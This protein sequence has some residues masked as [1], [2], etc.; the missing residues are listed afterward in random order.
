MCRLRRCCRPDCKCVEILIGCMLLVL[1]TVTISLIRYFLEF[2]TILNGFG[3]NVKPE[4]PKFKDANIT[5]SSTSFSH[6]TST[7]KAT[8]TTTEVTAPTVMNVT[9]GH[10]NTPILEV[11]YCQYFIGAF[12]LEEIT[13]IPSD[14][15]ST[16]G[17]F[18]TASN[19][20]LTINRILN[21]SSLNMF[22]SSSSVFAISSDSTTVNFWMDYCF[23]YGS[24]LTLDATNVTNAFLENINNTNVLQSIFPSTICSDSL[25]LHEMQEAQLYNFTVAQCTNSTVK[26]GT[27]YCVNKANGYCDGVND[28]P[29]GSDEVNCDCGSKSKSWQWQASLQLQGTHVCEAALISERWALTT[30]SCVATSNN[31]LWTII[32]G[33]KTLDGINPFEVK[34]Q[35]RSIEYPDSLNGAGDIALCRLNKPVTFNDYIWPICLSTAVQISNKCKATGSSDGMD[36]D[37]EVWT[38]DEGTIILQALSTPE[39]STSSDYKVIASYNC[40]DLQGSPLICGKTGERWNLEG[41]ETSCDNNTNSR[42][43]TSIRKYI[44]WIIKYVP[45]IPII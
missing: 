24:E 17:A 10:L 11:S 8:I 37:W 28:C 44:P 20:E 3:S 23:P 15:D 18:K 26:C 40:Q 30:K 7:L 33:K 22:Y 5:N 45:N 25:E 43:Y 16:S 34:R 35:I 6:R 36:E 19:I 21:L 12:E 13:S 1:V 9:E 38:D 4:F 29:D 2:P 42:N 32:L 14:V 27:G 41:S 39:S 31:D